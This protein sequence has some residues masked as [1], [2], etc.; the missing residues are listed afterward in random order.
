MLK[1]K[2]AAI[3]LLGVCSV[4]YGREVAPQRLL[5]AIMQV[6]SKGKA[7]AIGDNGEAVG[8]YQLHRI[9]VNEVNRILYIT[10]KNKKA[11]DT[12]GY[13]DRLD[14]AKSRSMTLIYLTYWAEY[15]KLTDLVLI[16]RLH[17]SG[18]NGYKKKC[19]IGYGKKIKKLLDKNLK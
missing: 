4:G 5:D 7:D 3:L 11:I 19:S 2:F 15:H 14:K 1:L 8:A 16:A 13:S 9:Y 17:N 10:S 12:Y 6:E 18:P